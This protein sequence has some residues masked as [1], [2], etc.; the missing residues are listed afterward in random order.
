MDPRRIEALLGEVQSGALSPA[1][2]LERLRRM[3]AEDLGEAVLDHHRTLRAGVPEVIL[4][5]W[6]TAEQIA[7]LLAAL[8]AQGN[9]ALATRV[10]ADKAAHVLAAVPGAEYRE[11]ARAVVVWPEPAAPARERP[12]VAVVCAGT[13]DLP[14]AEEA[15]VTLEFLGHPVMRVTDVGVAGLH[16]LF[17]HIERLRQ[18][19]AIL[20][21][22]GM[23]GALPSVVAGLVHRPVIA[24]PTSVGYGVSQGGWAALLG[25]LSSCAAG[26]LVV[27]IDNGFGAAVGAARICGSTR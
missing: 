5:E 19:A 26:V 7:R 18:A 24:V 1:D 11:L 22:A 16:R 17:P 13:S 4:G 14:V 23:E 6:K 10:S 3:P 2:A 25:M 21:V 8:A 12:T 9:G 20:V 15:V 27:N